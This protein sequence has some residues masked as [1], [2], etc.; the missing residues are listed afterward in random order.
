[1]RHMYIENHFPNSQYLEENLFDQAHLTRNDIHKSIQVFILVLVMSNCSSLSGS[2]QTSAAFD[3]IENDE[4]TR[5]LYWLPT[6]KYSIAFKQTGFLWH[7]SQSYSYQS[8]CYTKK[9]VSAK[10]VQFCNVNPTVFLHAS[11][12]EPL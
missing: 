5:F 12:F 11:N 4:G 1:M 7:N 3:Q 9:V 10:N 6:E 2:K 8:W